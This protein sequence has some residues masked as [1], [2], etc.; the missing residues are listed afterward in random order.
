MLWEGGGSL[1]KLQKTADI[2]RFISE[3]SEHTEDGGGRETE[4]KAG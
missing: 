1:G 3:V 4:E 2:W